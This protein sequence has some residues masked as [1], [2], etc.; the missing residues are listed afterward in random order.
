MK[1]YTGSPLKNGLQAVVFDWAGT[2]VDCG[3]QGPLRILMASFAAF[4]VEV[5]LAETR[6]PMGMS[7]REHVAAMC[8]MPRIAGLWLARYGRTPSIQDRE[9]VYRL[10]E[11][12]MLAGIHRYSVP[13]HGTVEAVEELRQLGLRIGSCT[14]YPRLVGELVAKRAKVF[15]YAPDVLVC[16]N[17]VRHGRPAPDMCKEVLARLGV[18][19]PARAV[20][21]GDT[22]N[23]VLEGVRAGMWVIGIT[24]SG[25]LAGLS[26]EELKAVPAQ[27]KETLHHQ[28]SHKLLLAGAHFTAP[29]V[30]SCLSLCQEIGKRC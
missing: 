21:I 14:G 1:A 19:D 16:S 12:S 10:A 4:G 25:A 15:G 13:M 26:E 29:D 9:A 18:T 3:C 20:K 22:V 28:I 11:E 23:D 6:E 24:L 5:T 30:P 7:K 2:I 8:A 27:E 17:D